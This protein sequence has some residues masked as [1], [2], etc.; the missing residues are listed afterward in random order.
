[1]SDSSEPRKGRFQVGDNV[2]AVGPSARRR[3]ETLGRVTK[4]ESSAQNAVF[5]YRVTFNDG[6]SDIFFGFELEPIEPAA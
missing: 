5:R 4:I 1:M 6:S 2:R 3:Q